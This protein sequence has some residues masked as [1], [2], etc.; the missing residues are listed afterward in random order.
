MDTKRPIKRRRGIY[1]LPNLFTTAALFSGFYAIVA[2]IHGKFEMAAVTIFIGMILDGLDGRVARMTNTESTFGTE[3]DSLSDL[4]CFGLAP[5]LLMYQWSLSSLIDISSFFGKLGWLAAFIYTACT[6]MRLARFNTQ[7]DKADKA[8]FQGL[9]SP[10]AAGVIAG[11]VWIGAD[12][13]LDGADLV[14]ITWFM[15]V[16]AGLL[17]VSKFRYR[18][19]KDLDL[20]GKIPFINILLIVMLFALISID[21]PQVLFIVFFI[22]AISGPIMTLIQ[23]HNISRNR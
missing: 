9:A 11:F 5:A 19:F 7:V 12:N 22:Y 17:M 8:Y 13:Q 16:I 14:L 20:K 21:P 18:S 4:I 6:A 10:A 15:T 3:Y 23:L 1:L 2:A